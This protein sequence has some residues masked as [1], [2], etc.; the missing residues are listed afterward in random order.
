MSPIVFLLTFNHLLKLSA[1]LNQGHGYKLELPL[2]NSNALPLVDS[3][4]YVKW[5]K[6]GGEPPG[7]VSS[8]SF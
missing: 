4:V 1:Y 8:K 3:S 6:D 2:Q 7:W 5:L